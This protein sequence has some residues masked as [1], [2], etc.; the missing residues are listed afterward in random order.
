MLLDNARAGVLLDGPS[1]TNVEAT[2][3]VGGIFGI[4]TQNGA[5]L[6]RKAVA[7]AQQSVAATASD[8]GL[9]VP[10]APVPGL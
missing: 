9:A 4:A 6:L 10:K 8:Q 1:A 2:L 3:I 7:T 5:T